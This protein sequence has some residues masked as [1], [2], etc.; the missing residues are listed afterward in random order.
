MNLNDEELK[1]LLA[2]M[3]KPYGW[4]P[5]E[6]FHTKK[7][8]DE[9]V[10]SPNQEI[11]VVTLIHQDNL[12]SVTWYDSNNKLRMVRLFAERTPEFIKLAKLL[13]PWGIFVEVVIVGIDLLAY[14]PDEINPAKNIF[15]R[16]ATWFLRWGNHC[17]AFLP[18][19]G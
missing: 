10:P 15:T 12:I 16:D 6:I 5:S 2:P 14:L 8:E 7:Q 19:Y 18:P 9:Y 3:L 4:K 13:K 11:K 1:K 17:I